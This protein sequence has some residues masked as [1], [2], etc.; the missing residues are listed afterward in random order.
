[1][2]RTVLALTV[3]LG[4]CA[5]GE[6]SQV[7]FAG[8]DAARYEGRISRDGELVVSDGEWT[9]WYPGGEMQ[10]QGEFIAGGTPGP[11]DLLEDRTVIPAAG[12]EEW[13]SFWDEEGRLVAEGDYEE[14]LRDDLWATWY[15]NG[16]QCCTGK[17]EL[18]VE[19]GYH[20]H[21]DAE[22]RK[23][24]TRSYAE[25]RLTGGRR[26][27]DEQG[28]VI[29]S[30]EYR[31]GELLSSEPDGAREP[32]VHGLLKCLEGAEIGMHTPLDFYPTDLTSQLGQ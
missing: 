1:M 32:E 18:G 15:E 22:G 30:G 28:D 27:L 12:R 13:W 7:H 2:V 4:S 19:H 8:S 24:D 10:A 29:W 25:G 6:H 21:W 5:G 14:G 26:V 20:I 31:D 9:F 17:F 3:L 16:H 11:D 23:R